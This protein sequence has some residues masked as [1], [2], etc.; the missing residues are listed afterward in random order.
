MYN[1][2]SF[3]EFYVLDSGVS[4][5]NK[6]RI[7]NLQDNFEN[8][9]I[10]FIPVDFKQFTGFAYETT[11]NRFLIPL[12]KPDI[13]R[14]IYLDVDIIVLKDIKELWQQNLEDYML[15]A[16]IDLPIVNS[17]N[18]ENKLVFQKPETY[19]NAGVLL[20]D[21]GKWRQKEGT[22]ENI[23]DR[24]F[25]IEREI[26]SIVSHKDQSLLNKYFD[27]N[28]KIL[29]NKFNYFFGNDMGIVVRHFAGNKPLRN[30]DMPHQK[31][32]WFYASMTVF[33]N[34]MKYRF[35]NKG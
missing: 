28:Y 5:N 11:Y 3:V 21:Y 13:K 4:E 18:S 30:A 25:E 14:A 12:L 2:D 20:I 6:Q 27:N 29:E 23:V 16:V 32:F 34:E 26:G 31:E 33:F 35:I 9:S 24:L 19:F 1:T 15:G 22:N 7:L 17:S 10:E 8:F